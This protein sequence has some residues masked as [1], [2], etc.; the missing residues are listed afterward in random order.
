MMTRVEKRIS[1]F[2]FAMVEMT[3]LKC[4]ISALRR[5]ARG[6]ELRSKWRI[7]ADFDDKNKILKGVLR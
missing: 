4:R 2:R 6:W 7:F 1:P 5:P 3:F